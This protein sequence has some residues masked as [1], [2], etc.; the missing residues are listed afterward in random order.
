MLERDH[1]TRAYG[2]RRALDG[3]STSWPT[4]LREAWRPI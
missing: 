1:L 3:I 4:L 2:A